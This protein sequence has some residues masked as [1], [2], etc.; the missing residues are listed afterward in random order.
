VNADFLS[1]PEGN[2][3][4]AALNLNVVMAQFQEDLTDE[5][6]DEIF[7]NTVSETSNLL[8]NLGVVGALILSIVFPMSFEDLEESD[9]A[10]DFFG[11]RFTRAILHIY[12]GLIVTCTAVSVITVTASVFFYK[13]LNFFMVTT[14]MK[15]WWLQTISVTPLIH[16]TSL[17]LILFPISLPIGAAGK[18][19]PLAGLISLVVGCLLSIALIMCLFGVEN[20]VISAQHQETQR[21]LKK[22]SLGGGEDS[23]SLSKVLSKLPD[24]ARK[25]ESVR[26]TKDT[27][28]SLKNEVLLETLLEKAGVELGDRVSIIIAARE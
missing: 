3:E 21:Y 13:H 8:I 25:L 26:L 27:I 11:E 15:I 17:T 18:I 7:Q 1:K 6:K 16:L 22:L 19:G 24:I 2:P 23:D 5:Q 28:K 4:V 12:H 10:V 9:E 20:M 14:E